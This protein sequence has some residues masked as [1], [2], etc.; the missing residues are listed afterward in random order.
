MVIIP[1]LSNKDTAASF[2]SGLAIQI[3]EGSARIEK[4]DSGENCGG[5]ATLRLD[6]WIPDWRALLKIEP[7][8]P[9]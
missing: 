6:F 7:E 2:L 9:K 4:I 1:D 8:E 3:R 5:I